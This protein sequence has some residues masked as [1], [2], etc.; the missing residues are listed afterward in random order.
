M[1]HSTGSMQSVKEMNKNVTTI[2]VTG[3]KMMIYQQ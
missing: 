3:E 1:E 2:V